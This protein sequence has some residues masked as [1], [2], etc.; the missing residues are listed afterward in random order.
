MAIKFTIPATALLFETDFEQDVKVT[1]GCECNGG[2][3]YSGPLSNLPLGAAWVLLEQ[4]SNLV[5]RKP[6][7]VQKDN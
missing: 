2:K 5:K 3:G 1:V 7:P 6:A 4:K